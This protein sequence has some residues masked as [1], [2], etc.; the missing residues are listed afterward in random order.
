M[1]RIEME[2]VGTHNTHIYEI[3]HPFHSHYVPASQRLFPQIV[4]RSLPNDVVACISQKEYLTM[5]SRFS[6]QQFICDS[7]TGW[8]AQIKSKRK[9]GRERSESA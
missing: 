2:I 4:F 7:I 1:D 5:A 9:R 3:K 6:R 8:L